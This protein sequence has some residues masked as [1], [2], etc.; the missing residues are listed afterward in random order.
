MLAGQPV[1]RQGM[2]GMGLDDARNQQIDVPADASWKVCQKF[3]DG[4]LVNGL[5]RHD[6]GKAVLF[7]QTAFGVGRLDHREGKTAIRVFL[8]GIH[9]SWLDLGNQHTLPVIR[10]GRYHSG[11][12]PL[13]EG[14]FQNFSVGVFYPEQAAVP[15]NVGPLSDYKAGDIY[16]GDVRT[17]RPSRFK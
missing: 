8:N 12:F 15:G 16:G 1:S 9:L 7:G 3:L 10:F 11:T 14:H 13:Y 17:A 2:P 4:T 5:A 6:D